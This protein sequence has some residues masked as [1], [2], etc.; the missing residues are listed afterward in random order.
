MFRRLQRCLAAQLLLLPKLA[1]AFT[2]PKPM[3]LNQES[4]ICIHPHCE[5]AHCKMYI[6]FREHAVTSG[7]VPVVAPLHE[8]FEESGI[9][10]KV[11]GANHF[12]FAALTRCA[13]SV[14]F[15]SSKP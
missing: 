1:Y 7:Q 8:F 9:C 13:A 4:P 2:L 14:G 6:N 10:E 12:S 5:L 3:P 11:P 15:I